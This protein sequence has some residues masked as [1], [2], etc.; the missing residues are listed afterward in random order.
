MREVPNLSQEELRACLQE[1]YGLATKAIDFLSLGADM[2]AAVYRVVGDNGA[3]FFLK[4][5]SSPIYPPSCYV[6]RFL[7]E[8]GFES[9]VGPLPTKSNDLWTHMGVWSVVMYPYVEGDTGWDTIFPE[10]W[11]EAGRIVRRVHDVTVPPSV[12]ETIRRE[13]FDPSG[14]ATSIDR[15]ATQLDRAGDDGPSQAGLRSAWSKH[16]DTIRARQTSMQRLADVLRTQSLPSVICH[17]D[18][19][20]G[21]LLRSRNR[22]FLVDWDDVM[23]APR[24][25][26][27]IFVGEPADVPAGLAN[28]PFFESYGPLDVN[29]LAV[30]YFRYERVVQ[31][32]IVDA[33]AVLN[34]ELP[35][36]TRAQCLEWFAASLEGRNFKAAQVAAAHIP[37]DLTIRGLGGE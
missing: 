19:H 34:E 21:N 16:Q 25:R 11:T 12:S 29:W 20:P 28:S 13:S 10:H 24:E 36:E 14:Y 30:T 17:A 23:L 26:D 1:Q 31:D 4:L 32:L 5:K 22:V 8:Q 3:E 27:F 18:L 7:N 2:S 35:A 9:V 37:A 33:G 6:P 15:L